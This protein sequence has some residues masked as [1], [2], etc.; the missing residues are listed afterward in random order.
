MSDWT[1]EL[2]PRLASLRLSAA[3]EAEIV[4]MRA[5]A[6]ARSLITIHKRLDAWH[7]GGDACLILWLKRGVT[8]ERLDRLLL[9]AENSSDA[10]RASL[11][12]VLTW[13]TGSAVAAALVRLLPDAGRPEPILEALVRD[14]HDA[15]V[16]LLES[17]KGGAAA[18]PDPPA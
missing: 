12:R 6:V 8:P 11:T 14:R 10:D 18:P 9:A 17:L 2:R 15:I 16:P 13:L 1:N 3:R 4:M 5:S 7:G